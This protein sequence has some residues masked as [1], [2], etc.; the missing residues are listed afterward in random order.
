MFS[1]DVDK[2][3]ISAVEKEP[4]TSGSVEVY[5][6]AFDFSSDWEGFDKTAV[7]K[8]GSIV[9]NVA[10]GDSTECSV[11]WEVL[12][13]PNIK[14]QIGVYGEAKDGA[15]LPTVW[16]ELGTVLQGVLVGEGIDPAPTPDSYLTAI[17]KKGDT[18]NKTPEGLL[19]LYSGSKLLS[20]VPFSDAQVDKKPTPGSKNAVESGGVYLEL[21]KK[22]DKLVGTTGQLVGFDSDGNAKAQ[23]LTVDATPTSGSKN[24]VESGGVYTELTKKQDK[25]TGT[26]GQVVGFDADG[27]PKAQTS[28]VDQ[29]P[30]SG[31]KN[32][33]ESGGVYAELVKKQNTLTGTAGQVVGFNADGPPKLRMLHGHP[34]RICW[35]TG[36]SLTQS[37]REGLV[38]RQTPTI[39]LTD[40]T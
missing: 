26:T 25:L 15:V 21:L 14:V 20:T 32:P 7:F 23:N 11:P 34:I 16:T 39:L 13:I 37:T 1:F 27:N 12:S 30:T 38:I 10:L 22:Q 6:V 24:P 40:G 35:I 28:S 18:L 2:V 29:T 17:E 19:G 8:A 36:T 31:S 33:V 4:M 3:K 9:R 5:T